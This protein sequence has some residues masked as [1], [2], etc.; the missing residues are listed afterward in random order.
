[1]KIDAERNEFEKIEIR[2]GQDVG[3]GSS[4]RML[5]IFSMRTELGIKRKSV[6]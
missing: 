5:K 1:M 6:S 2:R 4:M 3:W